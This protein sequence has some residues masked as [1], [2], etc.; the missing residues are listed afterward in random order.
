MLGLSLV[1][2]S[3]G[4]AP[5]VVHGFL[6]CGGFFYCAAWVLEHTGSVVVV[7]GL[8]CHTACGIL[9]DQ[10]SNSCLLNWQVDF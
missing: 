9:C 10:V 3:R 7:H 6:I 1:A 2:M 5:A 8:S 4:Y